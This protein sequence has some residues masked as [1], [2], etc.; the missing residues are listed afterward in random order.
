MMSHPKHVLIKCELQK[1]RLVHQSDILLRAATRPWYYYYYIIII[2]LVITITIIIIIIIFIHKFLYNIVS[3]FIE[4]MPYV[5]NVSYGLSTDK[6][7]F[8]SNNYHSS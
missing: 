4:F 7:R 2:T 1:R 3:W 6:K 8:I 5:Y